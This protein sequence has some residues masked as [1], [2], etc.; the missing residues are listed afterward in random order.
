MLE[1]E[2]IYI[3]EGIDINKTN[4]SKECDIC[5]YWYF[6][7]VG[8]KYEPYLCNGCHDLMQKAMGFN[9]IAIVYIKE[10][11]YRIHFWYIS[12]DDAINIMNGSNLVDKYVFYET[13]LLYIKMSESA[14]LTYYQKNR[15]MILNRA[16]DFY[17]NDEE[18]LREQVRDKYRNLFEE[19]KNKKKRIQKK[20]RYFNMSEEKK[21]R[22]KEY[23]KIIARQKSLNIIM[24][25]I[26]F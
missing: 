3:S 17:E 4:L 6:K 8:F 22:L 19:E 23:Q 1:Y 7:D 9:N 13:F 24:N 12:K 20:N 16:K 5:H 2:R 14:Y 11:A 25:K 26:A 18:R 10:N 15:D 21:K